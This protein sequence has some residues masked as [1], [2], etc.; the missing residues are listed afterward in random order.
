[1]YMIF[2]FPQCICF[3]SRQQ[4]KPMRTQ[5]PRTHSSVQ[6]WLLSNATIPK[7]HSCSQSHPQPLYTQTLTHTFTNFNKRIYIQIINHFFTTTYDS[8]LIHTF[9]H[10]D[11]I[12]NFLD[13]SF[14]K[15]L[16]IYYKH[17][18]FRF[19]FKHM[20]FMI[21]LNTRLIHVYFTCV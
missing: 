9:V 8:C 4:L 7:K 18:Y 19:F 11:V 17:N 13:T 21:F 1:M 15:K 12:H 3:L 6:T 10:F 14:L 2:I 16:F 20:I 5:F